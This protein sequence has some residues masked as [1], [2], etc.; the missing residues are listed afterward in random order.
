MEQ[1]DLEIVRNEAEA[2][3]FLDCEGGEAMLLG[4]E[5]PKLLK[6]SQLIVECHEFV[7]PGITAALARHFENTHAVT[8]VKEGPR[9]PSLY[10]LLDT[11]NDL[12]R[13]LAVCE[14]RPQAMRWLVLDPRQ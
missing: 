6:H 13:W 7:E 10:P 11:W 3:V 12:D 8:E 5:M 4:E 2:I 14:F 1:S 9:D